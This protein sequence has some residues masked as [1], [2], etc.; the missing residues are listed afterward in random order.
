M[1]DVQPSRDPGADAPAESVPAGAVWVR[2]D[3]IGTAVFDDRLP[4]VAWLGIAL[5]VAA[6]VAAVQLRPARR[7]DA[8]APMVND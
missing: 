3:L 2:A 5:I 6:G 4:P 8:A 1:N 7:E